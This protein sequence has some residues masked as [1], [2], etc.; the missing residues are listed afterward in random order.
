MLTHEQIADKLAPT[1]ARLGYTRRA[2]VNRK[3]DGGVLSIKFYNDTAEALTSKPACEL[4][5]SD[6]YPNERGEVVLCVWNWIGM[7]GPLKQVAAEL[8]KDGLPAR[9][10]SHRKTRVVKVK[11]EL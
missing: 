4:Y 11:V 5:A 3:G 6:A 7:E 8:T 9:A 10:T 1:L 2:N